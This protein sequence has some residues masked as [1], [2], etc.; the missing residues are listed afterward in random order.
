[1]E[2]RVSIL[3]VVYT[4]LVVISVISLYVLGERRADVYVSLNILAYYIS[5]AIIRPSYTSRAVR[6]LNIVL[7]VLFAIIVAFRI[8]EVLVS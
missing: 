2:R 7:F 4:F 6:A 3:L 1:V 5:Y 8:Y